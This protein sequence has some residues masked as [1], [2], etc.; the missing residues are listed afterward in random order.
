MK[1]P[2]EIIMRFTKGKSHSGCYINDHDWEYLNEKV[3][4]SSFETTKVFRCKRCKESG[5][6]NKNKYFKIMR[7]L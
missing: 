3:T 4:S 7:R 5:L 2:Q 6:V 1:F